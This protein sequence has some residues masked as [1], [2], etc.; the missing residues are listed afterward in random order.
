[1]ERSDRRVAGR[2]R[3]RT[4]RRIRK[5]PAP[6]L[7]ALARTGE[8]VIERS[9]NGVG[10]FRHMYATFLRDHVAA[11]RPNVSSL[12]ARFDDIASG[13]ARPAS[14]LAETAALTALAWPWL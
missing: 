6:R 1:M 3:G 12:A 9:G 14:L 11:L 13:W 8:H 2:G 5:L 7:P 10:L 4:A